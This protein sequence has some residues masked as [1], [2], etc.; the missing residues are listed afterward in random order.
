MKNN[1]L[2][3]YTKTNDKDLFIEFTKKN[4][5]NKSDQHCINVQLPVAGYGIVNQSIPLADDD[6]KKLFE[7]L[8][9]A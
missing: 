8:S 5:A 4:I 7:F 1:T 2:R 3:I 9:L 6:V